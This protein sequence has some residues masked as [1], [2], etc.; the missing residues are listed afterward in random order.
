MSKRYWVLSL[1]FIGSFSGLTAALAE[2][3]V[4]CEATGT[5]YRTC[6]V[7]ASG[8]VAIVGRLGDARCIQNETWGYDERGIWV[9]SGCRADFRLLN[10]DR[11]SGGSVMRCE[12]PDGG[13]RH[14]P[15]T[16]GQGVFLRRPLSRTPCSYDVNWGVDRNGIWVDDGCRAEFR[17][18]SRFDRPGSSAESRIVRCESQDGQRRLCRV[19]GATNVDLERQLSSRECAQG[20]NWGWNRDGIW[21]DG[22]CRADFRVYTGRGGRPGDGWNRPTPGGGGYPGGDR[23]GVIRC[24]SRDG[25]QEFCR[26]DTSDGVTL[27][28]Q[29][30]DTDCVYRD[31]WGYDR[32]GIWVERGC[33]AEFRLSGR[34]PGASPNWGDSSASGSEIRCESEGGRREFCRAE[35]RYG[36]TMEKQLSRE[37]CR[38]NYSWG[39]D[40]S[41]I[42]VDRGCRGVFR[43]GRR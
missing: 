5:R 43:L 10:I 41:G 42:W 30:S 23:Y 38:F 34:R 21:V 8:G 29:L 36:V 1:F 39:Y 18:A 9:R 3:V 35:T 26:A 20:R 27:E 40:R 7:D 37:D 13:Y 12:S 33:R 28:K 24:E 22:G 6:P 19:D 25:R 4:R 11:S 14:C 32:E 15:T 31:N 2:D 16:T 17:I